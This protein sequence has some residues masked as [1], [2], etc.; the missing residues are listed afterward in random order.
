MV[1]IY[2]IPYNLASRILALPVSLSS[3]ALPQFAAADTLEEQRL[4]TIALR[5]LLVCLTPTCVIGNLLMGPFLH[6]WVGAEIA[7][8]ATVVGCLLVFGFWMHGVGHIPSTVLLGRGRP[9]IIAKLLLIYI[10]PYFALLLICLHFFGVVGAAMAWALRSSANLSL[11]AF[12]KVAKA[13]AMATGACAALVASSSLLAAL[14]DWHTWL[15]WFILL[16]I[17]VVAAIASWRIAPAQLL[18]RIRLLAAQ[19]SLRQSA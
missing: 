1:P 17:A 5:V 9:D 8:P 13:E 7:Q 12:A 19:V 6:L 10:V 2:L 14:L 16:P 15:F 11:F 18:S 4:G 3:A